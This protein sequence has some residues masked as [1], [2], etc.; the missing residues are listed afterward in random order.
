MP[1]SFILGLIQVINHRKL[2]QAADKVIVAT[3]HTE[4][5]FTI[6]W[7]LV[8][9]KKPVIIMNHTGRCP[10]S[11]YKNPLIFVM[12]WVYDRSQIVFVSNAHLDMWKK[13]D[14]VGKNPKVVYNGVKIN[15]FEPINKPKTSKIVFGYLGRIEEQK[16]IDILFNALESLNPASKIEIKI[17][18][19]GVDIHK[20]KTWSDKIAL[21]N[22]NI[23]IIWLGQVQDTRAFFEP[24]DCLIFPS[25]FESFGLVMVE[26]WELGVPVIC[27]D[28][29]AF[30][31]LKSFTS[32]AEQGLIFESE[33]SDSL[34]D[35]LIYFVSNIN[36]YQSLDYQKKLHN[37]VQDNFSLDRAITN[38]KSVLL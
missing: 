12:K 23:S 20:Y 4:V 2:Y 34:T 36:L 1:I 25:K 15:N 6:P 9:F 19:A 22:S 8:W 7:I 24:I 28:I 38:I 27:S 13:Y 35:K 17:G 10:Q 29:S 32:K 31:E 11:L 37:T 5:F 3:C 14:L 18:G 16:G 30:I 21:K 33:N 26:A